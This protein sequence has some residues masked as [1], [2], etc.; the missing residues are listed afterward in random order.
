MRTRLLALT[1]LVTLSSVVSAQISRR[2]PTRREPTLDPAALPKEVP[3]V[4]RSLA[5]RRSRLSAEAYSLVSALRLPLA[6]G[7]ASTQSVYGTGTHADFRFDEHLSTS[8]DLTYSTLGWSGTNA[9]VEVGSR[10]SPLPLDERA[11]PFVDLRA[12]YMYMLDNSVTGNPAAIGAAISGQSRYS[13][14]FGAATGAG[15]DYRLTSSFS[16]VT[17]L[18]ALRTRMNL[19]RLTGPGSAGL[20]SGDRFWLT[21]YRVAIGLKYNAANALNLAQNPRQ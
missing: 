1:A 17:E 18:S 13:R 11:R 16:V 8:M 6:S 7:G 4:S 10:Y 9:T 15:L 2:P 20:P 12:G 19:Y 5:Y 14:G 21:T 3:E